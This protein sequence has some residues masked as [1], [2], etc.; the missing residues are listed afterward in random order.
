MR[1]Q[2][3]G[4][5]QRVLRHRALLS[6]LGDRD[7]GH[8]DALVGGAVHFGHDL[9]LRIDDH[10]V[11]AVIGE[12]CEWDVG[13]G[14]VHLMR[15]G[16]RDH[17]FAVEQRGRSQHDLGALHGKGRVHERIQL[18]GRHRDVSE[19]RLNDGEFGVHPVQRLE[20]GSHRFDRR[21]G[22]FDGSVVALDVLGLPDLVD[23]LTLAVDDRLQ[24]EDVIRPIDGVLGVRSKDDVDIVGLRKVHERLQQLRILINFD[25]PIQLMLAVPLRPH[26]ST[27]QRE[28]VEQ[29][30]VWFLAVAVV[31][32][33]VAGSTIAGFGGMF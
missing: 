24:A 4:Q 31:V 30:D 2:F 32:A 21:G 17:V 11:P 20:L 22:D 27:G 6:E 16:R 13:H 8:D 15:E 3:L 23:D 14:G 25:R 1:E 10:G 33:V 29:Q 12:R 5:V 7:L 18:D 28:F 19:F 26:Q 9:A